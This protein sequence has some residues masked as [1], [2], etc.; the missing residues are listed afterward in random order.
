MEMDPGT[1]D[2]AKIRKLVDLGLNRIS[3][4]VQAF[5]EELLSGIGRAHNL[6]DVYDAVGILREAGVENF[7]LD[8]ISGLPNQTLDSWERTVRSVIQCGPKHVATYDFIVEP[9]TAFEKW[10]LRPGDPPLPSEEDA[11]ESI[12]WLRSY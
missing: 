2:L 5:D 6:K 11:A 8:L 10:G 12:G 1:F 9:L 7:S 3:L 4:G